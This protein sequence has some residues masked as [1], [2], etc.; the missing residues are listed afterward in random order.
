M[1][2]KKTSAKR[3]GSS[4]RL[5]THDPRKSLKDKGEVLETLL[6]CLVRNDIEAFR[7]VLIAHLRTVNKV[8][9]AAETDIGRRT[10]YDLMDGSKPFNPTIG[11]LGSL[12]KALAA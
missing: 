7:D 12:F 11:T 3:K 1:G 4:L 8:R 9:L 5:L 2:K 6:E 10:L